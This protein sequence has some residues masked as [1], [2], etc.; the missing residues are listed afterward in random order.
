MLVPGVAA[1][2]RQGWRSVSVWWP[3]YGLLLYAAR[4]A[5]AFLRLG[6]G[7]LLRHGDYIDTQD[8]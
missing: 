3:P 8:H 1:L 7:K 4:G 5:P 6:T 2:P